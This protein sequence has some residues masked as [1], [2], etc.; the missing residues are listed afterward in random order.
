MESA[1]PYKSG[2]RAEQAA[3]TRLRILDAAASLS[4]AHGGLTNVP[5]RLVAETAGITEMT[6]YRHFP[7]REALQQS[8]WCHMNER[9]GIHGGFPMAADEISERLPALF[10][11]FDEAP[12]HIAGTITTPIGRELR[13]SQDDARRAAFISSVESVAPDLDA[14]GQQ[15]AAAILQLLYSA[16]TWL[17]LREQW[18][19]SGEA[20]AGAAV[21]AVRTLTADLKNRGDQ[22]LT[23]I[24]KETNR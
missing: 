1:R 14:A 10:A 6:V 23:S 17:S 7:N 22:P 20:A 11:S 18:S 16:H 4:E 9:H 5:N 2:L 24:V 15:Q 3:G 8:L 12:E 13:A 19:L 21:W